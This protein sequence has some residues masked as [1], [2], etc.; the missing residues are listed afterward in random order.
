[1]ASGLIVVHLF[2]SYFVRDTLLISPVKPI[3]IVLGYIV[4]NLLRDI[5]EPCW[6]AHHTIDIVKHAPK[7]RASTT[8]CYAAI[9]T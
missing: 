4:G 1:M 3:A 6:V 7:S 8:L 5:V 2:C 9:Y